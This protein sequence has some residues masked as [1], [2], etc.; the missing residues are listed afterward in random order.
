M[1]TLTKE[2]VKNLA[3]EQQEA[4]GLMEARRVARKERLLNRARGSR[5]SVIWATLLIG[6]PLLGLAYYFGDKDPSYRGVI[7]PLAA[8][9]IFTGMHI[10]LISQRL[11]ALV[12]LVEEDFG[13]NDIA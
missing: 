5:A 10:G 2:Q 9:M 12:E 8:A 7:Y 1:K 4:L 3:P 13:N 6:F 11:A